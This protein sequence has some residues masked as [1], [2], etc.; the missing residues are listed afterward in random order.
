MKDKKSNFCKV[1]GEPKITLADVKFSRETK[2][3]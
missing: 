1:S 3:A 2:N